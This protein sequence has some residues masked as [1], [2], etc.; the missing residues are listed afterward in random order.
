MTLATPLVPADAGVTE[1]ATVW[2]ELSALT[3][4]RIALGRS[5][6]SL[7]TR[8]LLSFGLAHARARDAVHAA[9]DVQR[10]RTELEA[11]GWPI[12]EVASR[13]PD[14]AA[15]LARP[16][17]GRRLDAD[18]VA[19]ASASGVESVNLVF[20]VS[21]GLSA[22]AVEKHA[23]PLLRAVQ[24]AM[25]TAKSL[26]IA[27]IVVATQ[28]RVALADEVGA[29]FGA[30]LAVSLIG[31]RPGLS[32]PDSLGVYLTANPQIGCTDAERW[33]ISNIHSA[34][35]GYEQASAQMAALIGLALAGGKTGVSLTPSPG[36]IRK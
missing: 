30:K 1:P 19:R 2:S 14:R 7:P 4:A 10:L 27:P 16:D 24:A 28:A 22:L 9:L 25:K 13:A 11:D 33:C 31:E 20:V 23:I 3:P 34:G 35:L 36:A 29:L 8:E 32:S 17:W 18:S 12:I 26:R 15:Y 5:G 21:D 6:V